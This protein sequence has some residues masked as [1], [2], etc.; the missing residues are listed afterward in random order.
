M[1]NDQID[2]SVLR[3]ALRKF[4]YH[5]ATPEDLLR[6]KQRIAAMEQDEERTQE[7]GSSPDGRSHHHPSAQVEE[8]EEAPRDEYEYD[9]EEA[10]I[11]SVDH[12][13]RESRMINEQGEYLHQQRFKPYLGLEKRIAS[14]ENSRPPSRSRPQSAGRR[15]FS[16]CPPVVATS[17]APNRALLTRHASNVIYAFTDDRAYCSTT[18]GHPTPYQPTKRPVTDP[19]KRGQQM[20]NHWRRDNFL[21]QKGRKDDLWEVRRSMLGAPDM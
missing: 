10:V 20:R 6:V 1:N 4:G 16:S 9:V 18:R 21:T 19:V 13:P 12:R 8:V 14:S 7:G 2:E 15:P 3:E 17:M 11:P 5:D